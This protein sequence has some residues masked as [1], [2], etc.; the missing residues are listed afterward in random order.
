MIVSIGLRSR[1][2][3][4]IVLCLSAPSVKTLNPLIP[5]KKCWGNGASKEVLVFAEE[6]TL[7]SP[8]HLVFKSIL[9]LL[10]ALPVQWKNAVVFGSQVDAVDGEGLQVSMLS[11]A[12]DGFDLSDCVLNRDVHP[13]LL[14]GIEEVVTPGLSTRKATMLRMFRMKARH[15][16]FSLITQ[17]PVHTRTHIRMQR[18]SHAPVSKSKHEHL[19]T[20]VQ[21][22]RYVRPFTIR[23]KRRWRLVGPKLVSSLQESWLESKDSRKHREKKKI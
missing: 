11:T 18:H 10:A 23:E 8:L 7:Q 21:I 5:G 22:R 17:T 1:V 13:Y 3:F 15:I 19:Q 9:E 4:L 16:L 14:V 6:G 2:K 12:G 20:R